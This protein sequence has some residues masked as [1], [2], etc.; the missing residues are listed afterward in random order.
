MPRAR[1]PTIDGVEKF[2]VG[3][4]AV[5]FAGLV[6]TLIWIALIWLDLDPLKGTL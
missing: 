4:A 3:I 2:F 6:A 1:A 5:G